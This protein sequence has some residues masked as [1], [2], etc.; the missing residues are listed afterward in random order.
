[1]T[2]PILDQKIERIDVRIMNKSSS[3]EV[4]LKHLLLPKRTR[5]SFLRQRSTILSN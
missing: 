4:F 3:M 1:M 2:E 5:V